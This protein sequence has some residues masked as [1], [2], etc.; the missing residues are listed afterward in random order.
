MPRI[1]GSASSAVVLALVLGS[2]CRQAPPAKIYRM[3]GAIV[4][5]DV[6]SKLAVINN[7]KIEGWMEP[8]TME[9]PV[10]DVAL[11]NG[12]VPGDHVSATIHVES[13][14]AFWIDDL[15]KQ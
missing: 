7:E 6:P 2:A 8:M 10:H 15:K 9:Y 11:L 14:L 12:L 3:R 4:S 13:D 1:L 5:V